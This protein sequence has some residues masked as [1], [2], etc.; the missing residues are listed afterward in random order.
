[1]DCP[2]RLARRETHDQPRG[3]NGVSEPAPSSDRVAGILLHP[4]SLPSPYGIGDLGDELTN[5]LDWAASAGFGLWQVLPLNPPGYGNSPYGCVSSVAGNP[6]LISP[7]RMMQDGLITADIVG[8]VPSFNDEHVQFD[9]VRV[10]KGRLLREAWKSFQAGDWPVLRRALS[11]FEAEER[12]WLDDFALYMAIK[13]SH[14]N[15]PW[16]EWPAG[17]AQRDPGAIKKARRE[18][19]HEVHFQK[20]IQFLFF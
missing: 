13:E 8:T 17:L 6:V 14:G 12:E 3:R 2:V 16:W 18:L 7:Q 10:W 4:T 9:D 11:H 19:N 5:F 1:M 15:A 20:F